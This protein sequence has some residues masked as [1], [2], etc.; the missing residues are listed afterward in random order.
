MTMKQNEKTTQ[1]TTRVVA[2]QKNPD[3]GTSNVERGLLF[4]ICFSVAAASGSLI[5]EEE[6]SRKETRRQTRIVYTQTK[7]RIPAYSIVPGE[8]ENDISVRCVKTPG[9][10][11]MELTSAAANALTNRNC[12]TDKFGDH[13]ASGWAFFRSDLASR[14]LM[15]ASREI[16]TLPEGQVK[17]FV[18]EDEG[19]FFNDRGNPPAIHQAI[20]T[21]IYM[22]HAEKAQPRAIRAESPAP[23]LR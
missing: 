1:K 6:S 5:W 15:E 9:G 19:K 8:N 22:A 2:M 13:Y 20:Q 3:R 10:A 11:V 17:P 21:A 12:H 7:H 4:L 16:A 14:R 23:M 18:I